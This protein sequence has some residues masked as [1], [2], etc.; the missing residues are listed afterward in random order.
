MGNVADGRSRSLAGSIVVVATIVVGVFS[1][2]TA[3]SSGE[4]DAALLDTVLIRGIDADSVVRY[5][6]LNILWD[7]GYGNMILARIPEAIQRE[8]EASGLSVQEME[9]AYL[10]RDGDSP[11]GGER[12]APV[13]RL[14]DGTSYHIVQFAGPIDGSWLLEL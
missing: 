12:N 4:V 11:S 9:P 6:G 1:M 14:A 2:P 3:K 7:Y 13:R 10:L 8:I 5:P